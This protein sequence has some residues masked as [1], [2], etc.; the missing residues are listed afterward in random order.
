MLFNLISDRE[1]LLLKIFTIMVSIGMSILAVALFTIHLLR[2]SK[3]YRG[4]RAPA[5]T[6]S[7]KPSV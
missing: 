4:Y 6:L 2:K 5:G 3:R 7:N 1:R